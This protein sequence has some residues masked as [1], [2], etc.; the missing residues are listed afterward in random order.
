[1]LVLRTLYIYHKRSETRK[2]GLPASRFFLGVPPRKK[3]E[4]VVDITGF[5]PRALG[6]IEETEIYHSLW[7]TFMV[8]SLGFIVSRKFV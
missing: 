7:N 8:K 1:M 3:Q 4:G 2:F 5:S 6:L